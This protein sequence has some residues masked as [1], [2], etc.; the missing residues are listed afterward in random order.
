MP[1]IRICPD[2]C[3][4]KDYRSKS[5]RKCRSKLRPARKGTG[6]EKRLSSGGYICIMVDCKEILEHRYIMQIY[7][8]RKLE[9]NEHVHH[10]NGIRT[11]NRIENLEL[12]N[13]INHHKHHLTKEKATYMSKLG[14]LAR[15][16]YHVSNF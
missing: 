7:L 4:K 9:S 6:V 10:K 2:C 5:C 13:N 3:G 16:G 1:N 14:H 8:G 15:W 11:D 12:L